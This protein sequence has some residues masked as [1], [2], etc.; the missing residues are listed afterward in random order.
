M[1][2]S[3][4]LVLSGSGTRYPCFIGAVKRL[5]EEGLEIEEVCGTSGGGIIAAGLGWKYDK[6]N[7]L[8]SIKFLEDMALSLLP[9]DLLDPHW[10]DFALSFRWKNLFHGYN[11]SPLNLFRK[12]KDVL[13]LDPKKMVLTRNTNGMFKGNKILKVLEKSLP[14]D[15]ELKIPVVIT[16]FNNNWRVVDFWKRE[17]GNTGDL[18]K[19]V[20][21][22]L[23]LPIIFDPVMIEGDLHSDGGNIANFPLDVFGRDAK[24]IGLTFEGMN[25]TRVVIDDKFDIA[26]ANLDGMMNASMEEDIHDAGPNAHVCQIR[27]RHTG[28]NLMM[29]PADVAEQILDGYDSVSRWLKENPDL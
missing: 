23:S 27:T 21:A 26:G 2:K 24:V 13:T 12:N 17:K 8:D 3:Y 6:E 14:E 19:L 29:T 15:L 4:K 28:L 25:P 11:F 20:R 1:S 10:F 7:P 18:A 9:S 22:T 5:L 16:T